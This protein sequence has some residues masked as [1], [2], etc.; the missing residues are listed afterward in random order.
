MGK[1]EKPTPPGS[2]PIPLKDQPQKPG[3]HEGKDNDQKGGSK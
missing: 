3:K 1:H 2:K